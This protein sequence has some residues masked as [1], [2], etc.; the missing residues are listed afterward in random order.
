MERETVESLR[1]TA[2]RNGGYKRNRRPF[3]LLV[4]RFLWVVVG[5]LLRAVFRYRCVSAAAQKAASA[6]FAGY[7]EGVPALVISNH[8][9]D[10]DP[11]FVGSSF[12]GH[13]YF[14]ASEHVF[15]RGFASALI[16]FF[17]NPIV[18]PKGGGD[19][20]AL[21]DILDR[22]RAGAN[23]CL[24]AEGNRSFSGVTGKVG[25]ATGKLARISGAA[26]ITYRIRGGY[27]AAPRWSRKMRKGP[28]WGEPVGFYPPEELASMTGA[29]ITALIRQDIYEDAYE[30]MGRYPHPYRGR[31]LAENLETALYLCPH[32]GGLG[33]LSSRGALLHCR[34]GLSLHYDACGALHSP[35]GARAPQARSFT[36]VRDW[37]LWQYEAMG[38]VVATAP[39]PVCSDEGERIFEVTIGSQT[40][41]LDKGK[42]SLGREGLR[43]GKLL[44]PLADILD[45]AITDQRTLVFST[46]GKRYEL[47]NEKPRSAVKYQRIFEVLM[48]STMSRFARS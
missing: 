27:F 16:R 3:H 5:P 15:R 20:L 28:V 1:K 38:E 14:V 2:A 39:E 11:F 47:T 21:R 24:F 13:L 8:T 45:L 18:F 22:L 7:R 6:R 33:T 17:F 30:T 34:C 4:W 29:A 41:F 35:P 42:L 40:R 9:T 12:P 43:C 25:E 48:A 26:L 23:V 44:F 32:C 10:L 37:W 31:A 19:T 36:T 46:R